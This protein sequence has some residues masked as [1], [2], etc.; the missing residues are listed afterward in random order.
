MRFRRETG[1]LIVA[2]LVLAGCGSKQSALAPES[3]DAHGIATI[4]WI[5]LAG[6]VLGLAVIVGILAASWFRRGRRG[7]DRP[8]T[9]T[10]LV[11]GIAEIGRAHV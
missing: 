9:M 11:L 4:W 3:P 10:V 8:G 6:S 1:C 7:S 5:M 2:T